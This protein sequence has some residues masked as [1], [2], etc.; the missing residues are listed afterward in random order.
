MI[1]AARV[2]AIARDRRFLAL[3]GAHS[4]S[5][6]GDALTTLTLILL[7]TEK[8]HSV[9][10]IGGLTLV[11]AVPGIV[12]GLLAGAYVDRHDRRRIM[13]LSDALRAVLLLAL[14]VSVVSRPGLPVLY[15]IAFLQAAVG[16]FFE[17]AR[18]GLM[19]VIVPAEEQLRANSL[20]QTTTVIGELTGA[21]AAGVLVAT[22]HTHW[23]AFTVDAATFAVSALLIAMIRRTDNT[24]ACEPQTTWA[25]I[26][27]GL[28]AVRSSPALRGLLLVFSALTFAL[29]PMAV[30]LAPYVVD[31]LHIS[32]GWIGVIQSG[33][34]AG[35]LIGGVL[36]LVLAKRINPRLMI[37]TGMVLLAALIAAL[38][39]AATVVALLVAHLIFGLLTVSI[40]TGIGAL[41]Q[42][43]VDNALM[44]RFM[45]L[46]SIIPSTVS[47][48]GMAF[49][50][51][52]GA[53][54]GIQTVFVTCGAVLAVGTALAWSQF[55]RA[56]R[57]RVAATAEPAVP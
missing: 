6:L 1:N 27:D 54:L 45:G 14:A 25:A 55:R 44:G 13:I 49:A 38:P 34:T 21:T 31:T 39:L 4:I 51:S 24:P 18:A 41:I 53:L 33:D 2:P 17:P 37:I 7:V 19:Q 47:I 56:A 10:A 16:T 9:A 22:L 12:I 20:M 26:T 57:E 32:T 42:T 29:S 15:L 5:T 48:F 35:N 40:Q 52:F 36:V 28:R 3:W 50:G 46:M 30:L 8:T 43:E 11:I 23:I